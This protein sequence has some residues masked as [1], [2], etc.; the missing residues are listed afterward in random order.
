MPRPAKTKKKPSGK[1]VGG[2]GLE[3][4]SFVTFNETYSPN[5]PKKNPRRATVTSEV[6]KI[7]NTSSTAATI[8]SEEPPSPEDCARKCPPEES[9][10]V[11]K[12]EKGHYSLVKGES[13]ES[14][15]C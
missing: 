9:I 12:L 11:D 13:Q 6:A 4:I 14:G 7:K 1:G 15:H 5:L 10:E 8:T 3:A 2:D